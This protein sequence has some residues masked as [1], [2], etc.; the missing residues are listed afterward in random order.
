MLSPRSCVCFAVR[1][2]L[3]AGQYPSLSHVPVSHTRIPLRQVRVLPHWDTSCRSSVL[4][5][6]VTLCWHQSNQFQRW[7]YDARRLA[8]RPLEDQFSSDWYDWTWG[9]DPRANTG[10]EP[11][12]AVLE[13]DALTTWAQTGRWT[14]KGFVCWLVG[15]LTSRRHA[16]VSQGRICTDNFT[17]CLTEIEVADP[18]FRLTQS[19]YT[20]TGPTSPST[21]PITPGAWQGSQWSASF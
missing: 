1:G 14:P 7:P 2:M 12:S 19:Q 16:S 18:T 15:C 8:G 13:A 3:F 9:K 11:R 21:D 10:I 20:D 5:H 4:P 17:C 6:P